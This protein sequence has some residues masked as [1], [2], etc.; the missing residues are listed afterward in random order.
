MV[1]ASAV[2]LQAKVLV[3]VDLFNLK[4]STIRGFPEIGI[5]TPKSSTLMVVSAINHPFAVPP[6][7]ETSIQM[8]KLPFFGWSISSR[9]QPHPFCERSIALW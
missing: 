9:L 4:T 8:D 3:L 7:M 1:P 5:N 6:F 2:F